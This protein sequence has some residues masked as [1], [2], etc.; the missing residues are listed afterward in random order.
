MPKKCESCRFY[1]NE[2]TEHRNFYLGYCTRDDVF[3]ESPIPDD[4][5]FY[6]DYPR[7]ADAR[8]I[9]DREGD[10]VFVYFEPLEQAEKMAA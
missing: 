9:C 3:A 10:G 5:A 4:P 2:I 7:I 1:C 8:K 6:Q